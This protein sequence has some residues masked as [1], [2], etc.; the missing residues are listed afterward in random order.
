MLLKGTPRQRQTN[1]ILERDTMPN[2]RRALSSTRRHHLRR[3]LG[4]STTPCNKGEVLNSNQV[5]QVWPQV[6]GKNYTYFT[7]FSRTLVGLARMVGAREGSPV[8]SGPSEG[9]GRFA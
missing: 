1:Q 4:C 6:A 9:I 3:T 8:V 2:S 5:I 7:A